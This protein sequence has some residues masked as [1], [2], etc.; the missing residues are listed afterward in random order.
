MAPVQF[1]TH[2]CSICQ[3]LVL[4]PGQAASGSGGLAFSFRDLKDG[5]VRDCKLC[6]WILACKAVVRP[7]VTNAD[8]LLQGDAAFPDSETAEA[9]LSSLE[10]QATYQRQSLREAAMECGDASDE[11]ILATAIF[12]RSPRYGGSTTDPLRIRCFSLSDPRTGSLRCRTAK[13]LECFTPSDNPVAS[14]I[15]KRPIES[16]PIA[17]LPQLRSWLEECIKEHPSCGEFP[18]SGCEAR[19]SRLIH[20]DYFN[21]EYRLQLVATDTMK[22]TPPYVALSYCWGA[23]QPVV[24]TSMTVAQF[25][26][27]IDYNILPATIQDAI[28]VCMKLGYQYLWV[29]ALCILQDSEADK[30]SEIS[31]MPTIYGLASI[32]IVASRA[33]AAIDGFLSPRVPDVQSRAAFTLPFKSSVGTT[34]EISLIDLQIDWEPIE[35]RA[36]TFQEKILSRRIVEFGTLQ[37]RWTCEQDDD[38][39][40]VT[41]GWQ[42][43]A[44]YSPHSVQNLSIN[45]LLRYKPEMGT[46]NDLDG[47]LWAHLVQ[48]CTERK[49]TLATDRPWILSGIAQ[50]LGA[51]SGDQYLAGLWKSYLHW[52]LLWTVER[53]E[54]PPVPAFSQG[55]SWSWLSVNCPINFPILTNMLWSPGDIKI[56]LLSYSAN[57][58]TASAPC[59]AVQ[60][61][62]AVLRLEGKLS[63]ARVRPISERYHDRVAVADCDYEMQLWDPDN[64]TRCSP[65]I[66]LYPGF[67]IPEDILNGNE[68]EGELMALETICQQK[69]SSLM[70]GGI[71]LRWF[72]FQPSEFGELFVYTRLGSFLTVRQSDTP[73]EDN[74]YDADSDSDNESDWKERLTEELDW[75]AKLKT[76]TFELR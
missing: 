27:S 23:D 51:A 67:S 73:R 56:R 52:Q 1:E 16:D 46:V 47:A 72:G 28:T 9:F 36:W 11:L 26:R 55:P 61:G 31:K 6:Q 2:S 34:G 59:G 8:S 24:C 62:S 66:D 25:Y 22:D 54:I 75:F 49:L 37:T 33:S 60:E 15:S 64:P 58:V 29:D 17:C 21:D 43:E 13:G 48:A 3:K 19:P 39:H 35:S 30:I 57:L 40:G 50:R 10:S 4:G 69:D 76:S 63:H 71:L 5:A 14:H 42:E 44:E 41:D 20:V 65:G 70:S 18:E 12:L 45:W 7:Q 74:I 32:T 53:S 68:G 38:W